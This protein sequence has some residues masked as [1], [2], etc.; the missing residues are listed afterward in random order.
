MSEPGSSRA[1]YSNTNCFMLGLIIEK[2]TGQSWEQEIDSR[3]ITPLGLKDTTFVDQEILG[4]GVLVPGYAKT[5]DGYLSTLDLPW[6]PHAST[7][8]AAGG[9]VSTISDLMTF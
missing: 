1:Y 5:P 7:A 6:Y 4:G 8:W 2:V 3:I 9:L